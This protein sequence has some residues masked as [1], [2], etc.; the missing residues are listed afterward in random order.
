M[1]SEEIL[2]E[3]KN[4]LLDS[5]NYARMYNSKVEVMPL[6]S[7]VLNHFTDVSLIKVGSPTMVEKNGVIAK[8]YSSYVIETKLE[9]NTIIDGFY[10][11]IGA[12]VSNSQNKVTFYSGANA[13]ACTNLS[14]FGA[15]FV[16]SM[17]LTQSLAMIPMILEKATNSMVGRLEA[18][19]QMKEKLESKTYTNK[20]FEDFK[21][22][23]LS[24]ADL[25]LFE[26]IKHAEKVMRDKNLFYSDMPHSQWKMLSAMTDIVKNQAPSKRVE[27]TLALESLFI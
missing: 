9:D 4:L 25:S 14:V 15:E 6:P 21:G 24:R 20:G 16:E 3:N 5:D 23:I 22:E 1:L 27:A 13:W 26:Y 12:L 17:N 8:S 10:G 19:K 11:T 2:M 18:I 7:A